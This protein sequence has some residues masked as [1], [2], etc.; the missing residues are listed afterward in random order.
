MELWGQNVVKLE[1]GK[2]ST[3]TL[4]L[5]LSANAFSLRNFSLFFCAIATLCS[6]SVPHVEGVCEREREKLWQLR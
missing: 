1:I 4:S 5:N 6:F 3:S 2:S